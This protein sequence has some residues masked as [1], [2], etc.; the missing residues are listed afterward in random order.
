MKTIYFIRHAQ[1]LANTGAVSQPERDIPLSD[2]GR[3]QAAQ[4]AFRLPESENVFVSE[5]KRTHETALPYC[6][7]HGLQIKVLPCLNEFSCLD[8]E[9]IRGMT[10]EQRRPLA[11]AYWQRANPHERTGQSA[12][13]FAEFVQRVDEFLAQWHT[14]PENSMVFGHGIW[15]GLLA[16]QALGFQAA[17]SAQMAA[18]RAFQTHLPTPNAGVWRISGSHADNLN[19][20]FQAA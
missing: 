12:D 20:R 2:L 11:Q 14:L 8:F 1:S 10:G 18:F 4:L 17:T 15:L 16:W 5:M 13:T 7:K 3:Q 6:Q 19:L 9:L